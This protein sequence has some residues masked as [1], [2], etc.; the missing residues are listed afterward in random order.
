M[1]DIKKI[2]SLLEIKK[3]EVLY[4]PNKVDNWLFYTDKMTIDGEKW[5]SEK[6]LF[7]NDLLESK[8]VKLA[9]NSLEVVPEEDKLRF[10][11]S[12][13]SLIFDEK[14]SIPFWVGDSTITKE[15]SYANRWNFGFNNVDKDGFF[16]GFFTNGLANSKFYLFFSK[17]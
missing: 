3:K 7:S 10:K 8:Q 17:S 11:S 12:I 5:K 9:I 4:T 6:A 13:N 2:E 16:I 14:V 15:F 1:S